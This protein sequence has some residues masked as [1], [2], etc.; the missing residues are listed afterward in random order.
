M[1]IAELG[2]RVD[3]SGIV[4]AERQLDSMGQAGQRSGGLISRSMGA[5]VGII[6]GLGLAAVGREAIGMSRDFDAA[7]NTVQ[8]KLLISGDAMQVLRDQASELG[9]TTSFSASQ[10]ADGMGFLAQAGLDAE[11]ILS[12]MPHTLS[13]A[14]AAGMDLATS[15]DIATNVMGA[16]RLEVTDLP[17]IVDVLALT[18]ARANTSVESMAQAIKQA[19]PVAAGFGVDIYETSA[20]IGLMANNGFKG[21]QA[22]MALKNM[23][24]NLVTPVG[25]GEKALDRLKITQNDLFESM[26]DGNLKFRG[27]ANMMEVIEGSGANAADIME[28]FG[29]EAGPALSSLLAGGTD[30]IVELEEAIRVQGAAAEMTTIQM[31]GLPGALK[32]ASSAWEALNLAYMAIGGSTLT[33]TVVQLATEAMRSMAGSAEGLGIWLDDVIGKFQVF[34]IALAISDDAPFVI[35]R[36]IGDAIQRIGIMLSPVIPYLDDFAIA[37]A[38]ITGAALIFSGLGAAISLLASP[39]IVLAA[40]A[41]AAN[42]VYDNW[43]EVS[44]W[45]T[46]M[47]GDIKT[48]A[49]AFMSWWR[50]EDLDPKEL[51]IQT[52]AIEI[53]RSIAAGFMSWWESSTIGRMVLEADTGPLADAKS[54]AIRIFDDIVRGAERIF[55]DISRAMQNVVDDITGLFGESEGVWSSVYDRLKIITIAG[56]GNITAVIDLAF[57]A[58]KN[59]IHIGWDLSTGILEPLFRLLKGDFEGAWDSIVDTVVE[60]GQNLVSAMREIGPKMLETGQ[61]L[62][63]SVGEGIRSKAVDIQHAVID[64]FDFLPG[65]GREI[66]QAAFDTGND[67]G[68]GFALGLA[69]SEGFVARMARRLGMIP[70]EVVREVTETQSP[71]KALRRVGLDAGQGLAIGIDDSTVEVVR[72]AEGMGREVESAIARSLVNSDSIKDMF[73]DLGDW[74]KNWSRELAANIAAEKITGFLGFDVGGAGGGSSGILRQLGGLTGLGGSAAGTVSSGVGG[75]GSLAAAQATSQGAAAAGAGA[76]P[77]LGAIVGGLSLIN[78][79]FDIADGSMARSVGEMVNAIQVGVK[80]GAFSGRDGEASVSNIYANIGPEIE[81]AFAQVTR[82]VSAQAAAL[83][84][85]TAENLFEGFNIDPRIFNADGNLQANISNLVEEAT[86]GAYQVAFDKLG[87]GIQEYISGNVDLLTDDIETIGLAFEELG[88]VA[89]TALPALESVGITIGSTFDASVVN[90]AQL[91]GAMGG[92][93]P[94]IAQLSVLMNSQFLPA[95]QRVNAALESATTSIGEWNDSLGLAGDSQITTTAGIVDYINAQNLST[96]AGIANTAAALALVDEMQILEQ[97]NVRAAATLRTVSDAA[98]L[99]NLNFDPMGPLARVASDSLV[100]LMG[101]LESFSTATNSYYEEYFTLEERQRLEL[102]Q[103]AA[104]VQVFNQGLIDA[105]LSAVVGKEQFREYVEGLDLTTASGQLAFAQA[106]AVSDSF[107]AV[108]NSGETMQGIIDQLPPELQASF[109]TMVNDAQAASDLLV[110][111]SANMYGAASTAAGAVGL[112]DLAYIESVGTMVEGSRTV[113]GATYRIGES[114]YEVGR[115]ADGTATVIRSSARSIEGLGSSMARE[116]AAIRNSGYSQRQQTSQIED[117]E[118]DAGRELA[119]GMYSVPYDNFSAS[120]HKGEMV[121]TSR[122]SEQLRAL[123]VTENSIPSGFG[124]IV[125]GSHSSGLPNVPFDGYIGELHQ[126]EAVMPANVMSFLRSSGIPVA[127]QRSASNDGGSSSEDSRMLRE[128]FKALRETVE[129]MGSSASEQRDMLLDSSMRQNDQLDNLEETNRRNGR[130]P[131]G[132]AA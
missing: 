100:Q 116:I 69:D 15:A 44:E 23:F 98:N 9:A 117:V 84:V 123:G 91:A 128:E 43:S 3:T 64:A 16:F 106:M 78:D 89:T 115:A 37:L 7:M 87:V 28:I 93:N 27:M 105:G 73:S 58:I 10:A 113:D 111:E 120:L 79:I 6:G 108:A 82:G 92:V 19:G 77:V 25:A 80:D 130:R 20:A 85:S 104:S 55:P 45:W 101:G 94:L 121:A 8:S 72:A 34:R 32:E 118:R 12:A 1:D 96:D 90:A 83:G 53:A 54:V 132:V 2:F 86:R 21:E 131:A 48:A 129:R 33:I 18:S 119:V 35:L 81:A 74:V 52:Q 63:G 24:L 102:A 13:L 60:F 14:A 66:E 68:T 40:I 124:A 122:V 71:S 110:T 59:A 65:V 62:I 31:Q 42:A 88:M 99:L 112:M 30:A 67:T 50:G 4:R 36:E 114:F 56:W 5:A 126:N 125:N 70:E 46:G 75:A 61:Q 47:W 76:L 107:A 97:E 41:T 38:S 29:R 51:E 103:S 127:S 57:V 49:S 109:Q 22:G 11:E 17:D 39:L 95:G 26:D